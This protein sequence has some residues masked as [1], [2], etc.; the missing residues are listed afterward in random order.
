M[1]GMLVTGSEE[2][3]IFI[4]HEYAP[5]EHVLEAEIERL[6]G[7]GLLGDDVSA[8]AVACRS[9]SSPRRAATSSARSRPCSSAWRGTAA[10]R[11]QAA[12]PGPLRPLG[13]AD[14]DELRRDVRRRAGHPR[15]RRRLVEGAGR[16][17]CH[18]PEV[19]RRVRPSRQARRL[20]RARRLDRPGPDRPR[21]RR[22]RRPRGRGH[23][24]R[25]GLVELPR[26]GQPRHPAGL[27]AAAGG[28][29][30]ARVRRAHRHGRGHEPPRRRDH[31]LRFFRNESCGK[32]VPCRV[33]STK[34]HTILSDLLEQGKGVADVPEKIP[35]SRRPSG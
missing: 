18:R 34:A 27:E 35:S 2:G 29:L 31:V 8:P 21:R 14:A 24:A 30:D 25:R 19:L 28:G 4:R 11:Q 17:R 12:V 13:Q 6:R 15:A 33:G 7:E 26:P 3:S 22:A 23:P 16:Q 5:E 9:R 10:S 32:C 1:L 20:L